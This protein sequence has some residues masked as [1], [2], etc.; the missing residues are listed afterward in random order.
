MSS[1]TLSSSNL[2]FIYSRWEK[3]GAAT[4]ES[5]VGQRTGIKGGEI[6]PVERRK[7]WEEK[8][9]GRRKKPWLPLIL[10]WTHQ[11]ILRRRRKTQDLELHTGQDQRESPSDPN[12]VWMFY[13][14]QDIEVRLEEDVAQRSSD[15]RWPVIFRWERHVGSF[16]SQHI[17]CIYT[18]F[19][20][21]E[22]IYILVSYDWIFKVPFPLHF[23]LIPSVTEFINGC[24]GCTSYSHLHCKDYSKYC[25]RL[26]KNG[27]LKY[28]DM[29]HTANA[30]MHEFNHTHIHCNWHTKLH[31]G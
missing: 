10:R 27:A 30:H 31:G 7:E 20:N 5:P 29:M 16:F 25:T 11:W 1:S 23:V 17:N 18:L 26:W 12:V 4:S 9:D 14:S 15:Q 3:R 6:A 28:W 24:W 13:G 19:K 22:Q 21:T 8:K 2:L